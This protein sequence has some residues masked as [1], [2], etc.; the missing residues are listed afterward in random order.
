MDLYP[1]NRLLFI[2]ILDNSKM[3]RFEV[4]RCC[5]KKCIG[6]LQ[7]IFQMFHC[8]GRNETDRLS[9][10]LLIKK[11]SRVSLLYCKHNSICR[12]FTPEGT[13]GC[14]YLISSF[15]CSLSC[16]N[17]KWRCKVT[18]EFWKA[19]QVPN[20]DDHLVKYGFRCPGWTREKHIC[21]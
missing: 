8:R 20:N 21:N 14:L 18:H 7:S 19:T 10:I 6:L 5:S 16:T 11:T 9:Y 3:V 2:F 17:L 12:T 13:H 4:L 15:S 1:K